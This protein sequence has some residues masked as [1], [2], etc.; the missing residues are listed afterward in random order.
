MLNV[1]VSER[2]KKILKMLLINDGY[3]SLQKLATETN[4]S[5]RSIYYDI[6][7]IN[8]WLDNHGIPELEI[9]RGKGIL[10]SQDNRDRIA[11][12][13]DEGKMDEGYVF[14]PSERVKIIICYI[15]HS[16]IPVY[17]EQLMEFCQVSRNTVFGDLRV[18]V[19]QLHDYDLALEYVSK[20]GY[21]I[22]GDT[23][24]TRALFF[25]YFND[26]RSLFDN[27]ILKFLNQEDIWG[28]FQKLKSIEKELQVNFV[29][30]NLLSLAALLPIM[31]KN[32]GTLYLQGL[33]QAE[34]IATKEYGL[35]RQYFP[36]LAGQEKLYLCLHLLGSRITFASD[37]V[38]ETRANQ[39][40]YELTKALV[41][42]FEKTACVNIE[43]REELERLLFV[44]I[45][46]SMYRYQYGIQIGN[47]LSDDIIREY[48]NLFDITKVVTKYLEQLVGLPIPDSEVAYLALH[49]GAYLKISEPI[50][51]TLRVLIVCANGI[52]TGNMLKR[53]IQQLLPYV[54]IVGVI[55]AV[56]MI[57]AQD[58]CDLVISTVKIKSMMPMIVVHPI[59]SDEDRK[60]ILN[61]K[62]IVRQQRNYIGDSLFDV[63]KKYVKEEDYEKM[64]LDII[65]CLQNE[66]EQLKVSMPE[67]EGIGLA[68]ILNMS[69]ISVTED[70]FIWQE[71][72]RWAGKCLVEKGSIE[73]QYIETI[74]TQTSYYGTYMFLTNEVML[75]HAKPEDGVHRVDVSMAVFKTPVLFP[76]S[77]KGRILF[78]L[79][80]K[81]QEKHLK[82]LNDIL[83]VVGK[84]D[85]IDD[86]LKQDSI[87]EILQY[88][89]YIL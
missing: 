10:L 17:V 30:G 49:F 85:H 80:A 21:A 87:E 57:N 12:L 11:E 68:E 13:L 77:R 65:R 67:K 66:N 64:R 25:L 9:A 18:V 51:D 33:K 15:I 55:A 16:Q 72:I 61:H 40:T 32:E 26:L 23:V 24:R 83:K 28:H 79:A 60:Y 44:H 41:T 62:M 69:K 73:E 86:L 4:V 89:Q 3:D 6:C 8:E 84:Q 58:L 75:A 71:S 46:T 22:A 7:R 43:N 53:E 27:G 42:E 56:D 14:L 35:I 50:S 38:F 29:D 52:S 54:H 36:D 37:E 19:N 1:H 31:Y 78:V 45:N 82:I 5:K 88:L 47:P 20:R 39:T 48:P 2:C 81:D 34:I 76:N 63:V 70:V 74:I 59:L